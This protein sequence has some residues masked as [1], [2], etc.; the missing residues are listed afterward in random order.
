VSQLPSSDAIYSQDEEKRRNVGCYSALLGLAHD[1]RS[2]GGRD[3]K[4]KEATRPVA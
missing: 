3:D 4:R 2:L 1:P